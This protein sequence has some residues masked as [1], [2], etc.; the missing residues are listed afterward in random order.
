MKLLKV[1]SLQSKILILFIFL[2]LIVQL[3]SFF[4]TYQASQKLERTQLNNRITNATNVFKTQINNRRYYLSAFAET[5]AKDYGLKSVLEEDNKSFLIALNNHR[6]RINS[7]LAMAFDMNGIV[8]AQLVTYQT[9]DGKEKVKIGAGQ[10]QL[11]DQQNDFID[12]DNAQLVKLNGQLY[13]LSLA[14]IKSGD[15]TIGWIGFGYLIDTELAQELATLTDVNIAFAIE[16]DTGYLITAN[17]AEERYPIDSNLFSAIIKKTEKHYVYQQ[18]SLGSVGSD[19]LIALLFKSKVDVLKTVGV[20]WGNLV[21][22]IILTLVLSIISALAIAKSITRPITQLVSQVKAITH[23]DYDGN[24]AVEGSEELYQLSNEFNH[25]TKA[26]VSREETISF[27]AF[28]DPLSKLP[29]RN[30]LINELNKRKASNLDFLVIQTCFIGAAD[31]TDTL[32]YKVSDDVVLQVSNRM[33]KSQLPIACF[34]LG[35]ENFVLLVE[36]QA[37][38]PLIEQ[39]LAE[40]NIQCQFESI[41]LHLQFVIGVAVST[42]HNGHNVDELLQ[43]SNVALQYAKKNKKS[44]QIYEP[45]FDINALERL[46]LTNSLKKAIEQNELVLFYQ[47]QMTLDTMTISHVEA[48]VRWQHPDKGLIPPDSFISIAEKT[49]QM[50]ALTRWVTTAAINQYVKWRNQ[51]VDISIAINISAENILDKSYPDFVI[52]LKQQHQLSDNAITLEVT[53]DAVVADPEKATEILSY[54]SEQGFKLSIDDY[55]T[56]YS[57]LAQLKQLPVQELK[58]DRSFVQNLSTDESDKIIVHSTLELAH[59]LGL[60][61]VAEGIEDEPTLLWLKSLGCELAQGFFI[62]KPL[63]VDTLNLWIENTSYNINRIEA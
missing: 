7:N 50:G 31:I 46:F 57:S 58:I 3:V 21:V 37:V 63:P 23:G 42:L 12:E 24:V 30:A 41:S 35:N 10:G 13:Q 11:F 9:P 32:G 26:I 2:L 4:S 47:P 34:H 48:L 1:R 27:Q 36:N 49:G 28:H 54:L 8:F 59:N 25:M 60:S 38:S 39:L 44:F 22:L 51:G 29:N 6:K 14:A 52:A 16:S 15:R 17:S 62:S 5:A 18:Y 45:Q 55:G 19:K 53:E 40:L 61:V 56:G 20:Q 33:L 43:K